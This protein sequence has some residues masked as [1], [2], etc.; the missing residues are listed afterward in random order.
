LDK[1]RISVEG[2][3]D[4]LVITTHFPHL[5]A[6]GLEYY[7]K[8]PMSASLA[9]GHKT[10]EVHVENL[11]S[12]IHVTVHNGG[13]TL[14]LP[15][16]QYNIDA[17]SDWGDVISDFQG[18]KKRKL[19]LLGYQFVQPTAAAHKLYVRACFGDIMI[20]KPSKPASGATP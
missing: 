17:R 4:E 15:E 11:T 14:R 10:G 3:G 6:A 7:I 8:A 13:I 2:R 5:N 19:W 1:V 9:V 12:D 18:S 16:G 20:L